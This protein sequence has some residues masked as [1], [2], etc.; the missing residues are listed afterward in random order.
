MAMKSEAEILAEIEKFT[1]ELNQEA[2]L[3]STR[4][5]VLVARI[6]TL[7]WILGLPLLLEER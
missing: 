3:T 5:A 4:A 6:D 7:R 2:K 1:E